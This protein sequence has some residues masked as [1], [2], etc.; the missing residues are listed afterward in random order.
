MNFSQKRINHLFHYTLSIEKIH[1]I[2]SNGFSPSYCMEEITDLVYLIP[3]VSFCNIP[4]RDVDLY[5]RYGNYGLG[6]SVDWALKNRI[7]PV[8]Y[9]HENSPFNS[10]H[11]D[12]N[13]ILL[14]DLANGQL[15][16]AQR[17]FQEAMD[18]GVAYNF[19]PQ[20]DERHIKLLSNINMVTVPALQFFKNWKVEYEGQELITYQEREWRFIPNLETEKKIIP[21][22]DEVFANYLD[23]E[24]KPKPHL[25]QYSLQID[26]ITDLRYIII[27]NEEERSELINCLK[28]KFGEKEVIEALFSGTL[29]ILT[30]NQV[31]ND[32]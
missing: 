23:K 15:T 29:F 32:F 26:K 21:N 18:K 8:I 9:I 12:I 11:S 6:M 24:I 27:N 16:E 5:M 22:S 10:L 19:S 2:I 25:P 30:N 20:A 13:K 1:C 14:W 31:K 4:I 17:Q 7:S 3:M 28:N